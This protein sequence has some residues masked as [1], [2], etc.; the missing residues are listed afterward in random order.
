MPRQH[1]QWMLTALACAAI[2]GCATTRSQWEA[3]KARD[4]IEAYTDFLARYPASE[5]SDAA[6]VRTSQ[7][8]AERDWPKF[9]LQ[10]RLMNTVSAYQ[11]ILFHEPTGSHRGGN[12]PTGWC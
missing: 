4:S 6:R 1:R 11:D 5:F 7:L 12:G 8:Q 3:A 9:W 10:A 2:I